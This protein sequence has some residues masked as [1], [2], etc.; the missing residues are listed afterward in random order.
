M[1]GVIAK[2]TAAAGR[3]DELIRILGDATISMPGCVRYIIARDAVDANLVWITEVW[4]DQAAHDKSLT[5]PRVQKA[6]ADAR[7]LIA[8]FEKVAVTT[9]VRGF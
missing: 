7:P 9:P 5:L 6:M 2:L 4:D 8:N 3:R 1:Y